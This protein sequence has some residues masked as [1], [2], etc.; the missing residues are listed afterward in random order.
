MI[1]VHPQIDKIYIFLEGQVV[2]GGRN[3]FI[4]H[5]VIS[6]HLDPSIVRFKGKVDI[7]FIY[8]KKSNGAEDGAL[9]YT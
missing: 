7:L 3:R 6:K 9:R 1:C 4:K 5:D 2:T 8:N